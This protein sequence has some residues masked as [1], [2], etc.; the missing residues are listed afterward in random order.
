M[1][2]NWQFNRR[3]QKAG[4]L[5]SL[6][7]DVRVVDRDNE[8]AEKGGSLRLRD[9]AVPMYFTEPTRRPNEERIYMEDVEGLRG[10]GYDLVDMESLTQR[11]V[12]R[13]SDM[14][15][16][17]YVN[18]DEQRAHEQAKFVREQHFYR[19]GNAEVLRLVTRGQIEEGAVAYPAHRSLVI[20]QTHHGAYRVDGKDILLQRFIEDQKIRHPADVGHDL[21][22]SLQ[23]IER[24]SMESHHRQKEAVVMQQQQQQ[25]QQQLQQL[26]Q[27][28][29][30]Q[31]VLLIPDRL[32]EDHRQ[33]IEELG[34]E[35]QRLII[36]HGTFDNTTRFES[37]DS[38]EI[39]P[40]ATLLVHAPI[41]KPLGEK[42]KEHSSRQSVD[43][44][45]YSI[46]DL[47]LARQNALLTR[48]LLERD[49]REVGAGAMVDSAS[50]LE[51]QSL[52]GQVAIATQTDR[53]AS[54][55]TELPSRSRSDNDESE[56]EA[57]MRRK[58]K[59]KKRHGDGEPRRIRTLWM[60]SPIQEEDSQYCTEKR[61]N[62]LR[63]KIKDVKEC[64]RIPLE[65][66]VLQAISDSLDENGD[67][68][69]TARRRDP[70]RDDSNSREESRND[71]E[72]GRLEDS[73]STDFAVRDGRRIV[74]EDRDDRNVTDEETKRKSHRGKNAVEPSFRILE[75]EMSSLSRKLSK[76]AGKRALPYSNESETD[77]HDQTKKV[78]SDSKKIAKKLDTQVADGKIVSKGGEVTKSK[79][80]KSTSRGTV[81][82]AVPAKEQTKIREEVGEPKSRHLSTYRKIQTISTG[83][84]D[85]EESVER[86]KKQ[87]PTV[88][89][90]EKST[91]AKTSHMKLKRQHKVEHKEPTKTAL[92]VLAQ[93]I[94]DQKD[95]SDSASK[96]SIKSGKSE[97]DSM[98][99]KK[100]SSG[101]SGAKTVSGSP[102]SDYSKDT[103]ARRI[104]RPVQDVGKK[105]SAGTSET[106]SG[107]ISQ[108]ETAMPVKSDAKKSVE[109]TVID[110][111]EKSPEAP[112]LRLKVATESVEIKKSAK[113]VIPVLSPELPD[114]RMK[115][116][117]ETVEIKKSE[118]I[119]TPI[120]SPEVPDS[121]IHTGLEI[122]RREKILTPVL[123]SE[124]PEFRTKVTPEGVEVQKSDKTLTPVLSPEVPQLALDITTE[125]VG[126]Q[127][128]GKTLTPSLSPEMPE[129][130]KIIPHVV[131]IQSSEKAVTPPLSPEDKISPEDIE[132]QKS[133]KVVTPSM[134]PEMPELLKTVS[135][136]V[137]IQKIKKALTPSL[138]PEI[139]ESRINIVPETAISKIPQ[140]PIASP[141]TPNLMAEI[142][143][144][145]AEAHKIE[146]VQ[147]L[148]HEK[149]DEASAPQTSSTKK[150]SDEDSA[151]P[152]E[153][154]ETLT[155]PK[156]TLLDFLSHEMKDSTLSLQDHQQ[157]V[158]KAV[159]NIKDIVLASASMESIGKETTEDQLKEDSSE[160]VKLKRTDHFE[161]WEEVPADTMSGKEHEI[162]GRPVVVAQ[163]S[164][165]AGMFSDNF[166]SFCGTDMHPKDSLETRVTEGEISYETLESESSD[167]RIVDEK[168]GHPKHTDEK[169]HA[170]KITGEPEERTTSQ[171]ATMSREEEIEKSERLPPRTTPQPQSDQETDSLKRPTSRTPTPVPL[172]SETERAEI[173][174]SSSDGIDKLVPKLETDTFPI[175]EPSDVRKHKTEPEFPKVEELSSSPSEAHVEIPTD[176]PLEAIMPDE[177]V[178]TPEEE[179]FEP[180]ST[181]TEIRIASPS[182]PSPRPEEIELETL[183]QKEFGIADSLFVD[184]KLL[185]VSPR[186]EGGT[187]VDSEVKEPR[188]EKL[189]D[190]Q[191]TVDIKVPAMN[192]VELSRVMLD[193]GD[194]SD[195]SEASSKTM[196][197]ARP[198]GTPRHR[199]VS[200]G[201]V[202]AFDASESKSMDSETTRDLAVTDLSIKIS[203]GS[204]KTSES[205]EGTEKIDTESLPEKP[206]TDTREREP[207][208]ESESTPSV[209][210][211]IDEEM[212]VFVQDPSPAVQPT[213][214]SDQAAGETMEA[215]G[216]R[217]PQTSSQISESETKLAD[218]T[219]SPEDFPKPEA[220]DKVQLI[221]IAQEKLSAVADGFAS[222]PEMD[223][224]L[225]SADFSK[226]TEETTSSPME[227]KRGAVIA[228]IVKAPTARDAKKATK[229]KEPSKEDVCK[230][231]KKTAALPTKTSSP[232]REVKTKT[233][234][235]ESSKIG[236][237]SKVVGQLT[238][239][240]DMKRQARTVEPQ[241]DEQTDTL[242]R[243]DRS[244]RTWRKTDRPEKDIPQQDKPKAERVKKPSGDAEKITIKRPTETRAK[245]EKNIHEKTGKADKSKRS[246]SET[247]LEQTLKTAP[248]KELED[249][250]MLKE[251][252][253]QRSKADKE[254]T[255]DVFKVEDIETL[256][257][258]ETIESTIPRPVSSDPK[259]NKE[260]M[261]VAEEKTVP[262]ESTKPSV[263]VESTLN[264]VVDKT[265]KTELPEDSGEDPRENESTMTEEAVKSEAVSEPEEVHK[266]PAAGEQNIEPE[267][268]DGVS[269]DRSMQS[270]DTEDQARGETAIVDD[271]EGE[272]AE[273][274]DSP[275][276]SSGITTGKA[277]SQRKS[278]KPRRETEIVVI[279]SQSRYMEWYKQK[280]EE[281][282]RKRR[283]RK[284]TDEEEE[285]PKWLRKS[286]RQRW[287]RS[288]PDDKRI[289]D[290]KIGETTPGRRKKI[291]PL[292]NVESE[293]LKAIVRQGRKLRKAQGERDDEPQI[294]I[295]APEKPP[296]PHSSVPVDSRYHH[297][298][299][300]VQHSEYSYE[301]MPVGPFYLH[302]PPVPHPSPH[303]F[304][305]LGPEHYQSLPADSTCPDAGF[306]PGIIVQQPQTGGKLRHQQIL[307]KKSVFDIAYSEA[308]PS[309]L[310]ADSTTPPS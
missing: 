126:M 286:T 193:D 249:Q 77:S 198:Y 243:S 91:V 122:H 302:P 25:Q 292:V 226:R 94:A 24:R 15:R 298:H 124:A 153:S 205:I 6:P 282:E 169:D 176:P 159:E 192:I 71:E 97:R 142:V 42:V 224:P 269:E 104:S 100:Y 66:E 307:E 107:K 219:A 220:S 60:K 70:R 21:H 62:V 251:P 275:E 245:V 68:P 92:P 78:T 155:M 48:L 28:Q 174:T 295:F 143:S 139:P 290:P 69:I 138:S 151:E 114:S 129:S 89:R 294:I 99:M 131:E 14:A 258:R 4:G 289:F 164:E 75:R 281:M 254:R 106:S 116:I 196:L 244:R 88:T 134:S 297:H 216:G 250:Q 2:R 235:E 228:K 63:K 306:D 84:S 108:A 123:S 145:T 67:T 309:H 200:S 38:Q 217:E 168:S 215:H 136:V 121:G 175:Q 44:Q 280:R 308:A 72:N 207:Q 53:T 33:H 212:I 56:E 300:L 208:I 96:G 256:P 76:L 149:G 257:I 255:I 276:K 202:E 54:T 165:D 10:Q 260:D 27:H 156:E 185:K 130:I 39:V 117:P 304:E 11:D 125:G 158:T 59:S 152:S 203:P 93:E 80:S 8:V 51:T 273:V 17:A 81:S 22:D 109:S 178:T 16:R 263:E 206:E 58:M 113:I 12:E 32:E 222:L 49:S 236:K 277:A 86:I 283:E 26:Q 150:N 29:Q 310:R 160:P 238:R 252:E 95:N 177:I 170:P 23:D 272:T 102:S 247:K 197:T 181:E 184:A 199:P 118:K 186:S 210:R 237:Q 3:N 211:K 279:E 64:R 218:S 18:E 144:E 242:S 1:R 37:K 296:T 223:E 31:Q 40:A 57:R 30:H 45:H 20:D 111:E 137:G 293:Q 253:D 264:N 233:L 90:A 288:G 47:E 303:H 41:T 194:E 9:G 82:E 74:A 173:K 291:K 127:K 115:I 65:P 135:Q 262:D 227:M 229:K 305:G 209:S 36:D 299:H 284:D 7:G 172:E 266:T 5:A 120:L 232:K 46:H 182:P 43:V 110:I 128:S 79:R 34:P 85:F 163:E 61:T 248:V 171:I 271:A 265:V 285:R 147:M 132:M 101:T 287:F 230:G 191:K 180:K 98:R 221:Q 35:V 213:A 157:S 55:Q 234:R 259:A 239:S 241:V 240:R 225:K 13:Q 52:P 141:E 148:E 278:T 179:S 268:V 112:E 261:K 162:Q 133:E 267:G 167:D 195:S 189:D 301:K 146:T 83:S 231:N 87:M 187:V 183:S 119:S 50:Y 190:T 188:D 204:P 154:I 274:S 214:T 103:K 140:T 201:T 166:D 73:S 270:E 19:D 161:E 105:T 246:V